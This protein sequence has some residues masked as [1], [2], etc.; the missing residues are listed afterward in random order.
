MMFFKKRIYKQKLF[1]V[2]L[3]LSVLIFFVFVVYSNSLWNEFVWDDYAGIVT[4]TYVHNFDFLNF[5]SKSLT[6]GANAPTTFWRPLILVVFSG[7]W[8]FFGDLVVPYHLVNILLHSANASLFFLLFLRIFRRRIPAFLAALVFA[9]HPLNTEAITYI[10]GIGDPLS[11]FFMLLGANFYARA[12][13]DQKRQKLLFSGTALVFLLALLSKESALIFPIILLLC[14]LFIRRENLK[15]W[16]DAIVVAQTTLPFFAISAFYVLAR[17]SIF[18]FSE[19]APDILNLF[20]FHDRFLTF[21]GVFVSYLQLLFAPLHLHMEWM[22]P[23]VKSAS[24][25]K[26][27]F[28]IFLLFGIIILIV[29]QFKKRPAVSFGFLWFLIALFP[30]SNLLFGMAAFGAEHWLYFSFSGFFFALFSLADEFVVKENAKLFFI[31][32]LSIWVGWLSALTVERNRDW[33]DTITLFTSTL[34][35]SPR[36]YRANMSLGNGYYD[37]GRYDDAKY[38]YERTLGLYPN[39]YSAYARLGTLSL[40]LNKHDEAIRYYEHS[41]Q[42][43]SVN[44]PAFYPLLEEYLQNKEYG[45][46]EKVL[47]ERSEKTKDREEAKRGFVTLAVIAKQ[48]GDMEK[49]AMY[50]A[51]AQKIA[52]EKEDSFWVFVGQ[53]L[54]QYLGEPE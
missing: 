14:G 7:L 18:D 33:Q 49:E 3:P 52:S 41:V 6:D 39:S 32:F 53:F 42:I 19:N 35:E 27:L 11:V 23:T 38:Y 29:T 9:V 48:N 10:S 13:Q 2:A 12:I 5:F 28:G 44:S 47:G 40:R 20:S 21:C 16:K 54:N 34:Q 1:S 45:K 4:N 22:L 43:D 25:P 36:S 37:I 51:Q 30:N 46:A 17:K 26:T 8:H 15:T 50:Y 24:E 31:V